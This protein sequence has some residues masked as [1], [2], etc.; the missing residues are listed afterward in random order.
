M[1]FFIFRHQVIHAFGIQEQNK[2][3]ENQQDN[4]KQS[5]KM[6]IRWHK[7]NQIPIK[8]SNEMRQGTRS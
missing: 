4:R 6:R 1:K 7:Q 2:Q 8:V 5:N 3:K